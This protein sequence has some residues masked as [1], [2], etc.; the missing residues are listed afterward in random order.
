MIV[1]VT[2]PN[3]TSSTTNPT[4]TLAVR[5]PLVTAWAI[6]RS[7]SVAHSPKD[8]T[9]TRHQRK[10]TTN[11]YCLGKDACYCCMSS[12]A[13]VH[14]LGACSCL[15]GGAQSRAYKE[16]DIKFVEFCGVAWRASRDGGLL[17]LL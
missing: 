4:S 11:S 1:A 9:T 5:V 13:A 2:C 8:V 3:S 16:G 12:C 15:W 10:W 7:V 6:S 17:Q 14:G